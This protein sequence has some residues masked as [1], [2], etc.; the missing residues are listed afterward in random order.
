MENSESMLLTAEKIFLPPRFPMRASYNKT[1]KHGSTVIHRHLFHEIVIYKEGRGIHTI[2]K[3][4]FNIERGSV[5]ILTPFEEHQIETEPPAENYLLIFSKEILDDILMSIVD[6]PGMMEL[7]FYHFLLDNNSSAY[8]KLCEDSLKE[9]SITMENLISPPKMLSNKAK[10]LYLK[11]TLV[12]FL[13]L[14]VEEYRKLNKCESGGGNNKRLVSTLSLIERKIKH[15]SKTIVECVSSNLDVT[16]NYLSS[17][18]SKK[19]GV[20]LSEYIS[21]RKISRTLGEIKS[22]KSLYDIALSY[23]FYDLSHYSRVF[24]KQMKQTPGAYRENYQANIEDL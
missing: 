5:F 2:D 3:K 15:D 14:L 18:F 17:W 22:D 19:V 24:K 8:F 11:N 4:E 9:V 23:G 20:S 21:K 10:I 1:N 16:K 7:V 12:N 13:L 6:I